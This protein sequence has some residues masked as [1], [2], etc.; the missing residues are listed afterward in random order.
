MSLPNCN[1]LYVR[2]WTTVNGCTGNACYGKHHRQ[3][4]THT[5]HSGLHPLHVGNEKVIY[6][7]KEEAELFKGNILE[8]HFWDIANP[9]FAILA[10]KLI[11]VS[12]WQLFTYVPLFCKA[13]GHRCYR[14]KCN[15]DRAV[16]NV[17][18]CVLHNLANCEVRQP[19]R[20]HMVD[21]FFVFHLLCSS[22]SS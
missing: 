10:R 5:S 12:F 9:G 16:C 1:Y 8:E 13:L 3:V 4:R 15:S 7:C 22:S 14:I 21:T 19:K 2:H 11:W 6:I 17:L 20:T 18:Q